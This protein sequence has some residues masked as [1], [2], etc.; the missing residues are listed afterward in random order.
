MRTHPLLCARAAGWAR[1]CPAPRAG[2]N[3][4]TQERPGPGSGLRGCG[5][6]GRGP[7][8]GPVCRARLP[9][10]GR[11]A[12]A[13][14][15]PRG[16]PT[17]RRLPCPRRRQPRPLMRLQCGTLADK[18]PR[19]P[20]GNKGLENKTN[21]KAL[22]T[23]QT[24]DSF[25]AKAWQSASARPGRS[26]A[27]RCVPTGGSGDGGR[28]GQIKSRGFRCLPRPRHPS[29]APERT[30]RG[31]WRISGTAQAGRRGG[32]RRPASAIPGGYTGPA[33][34]AAALPARIRV[35][36]RASRCDCAFQ[37]RARAP[38]T[39]AGSRPEAR[40]R[41]RG[42]CG[43]GSGPQPPFLKRAPGRRERRARGPTIRPGTSGPAPPGRLR[44]ELEC[45]PGSHP[46]VPG[47]VRELS[48]HPGPES[49][50]ARHG[51]AG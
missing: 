23:R 51:A 38:G 20:R 37:P 22:K 4:A 6:S 10:A 45:R 48:N 21:T 9:G 41:I 11:G 15:T 46:S 25:E 44:P 16:A 17:Q 2:S 14:R 34:T 3:S 36:R 12:R 39:R 8:R 18:T 1:T 28:A 24:Q 5:A 47:R 7:G 42:L 49:G 30:P 26:P 35:I 13:R 31:S 32:G 29:H 50:R 43:L 40:S 27:P 19:T 33:G